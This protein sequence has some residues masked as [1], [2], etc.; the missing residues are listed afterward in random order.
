MRCY[1]EKIWIF[2]LVLIFL[3][4]SCTME[5]S[6]KKYI[7]S[8]S[9]DTHNDRRIQLAEY[10]LTGDYKITEEEMVASLKSF[11]DNKNGNDR[12]GS[13][14]M[15]GDSGSADYTIVK[16]NSR[17]VEFSNKEEDTANPLVCKS[18]G[19]GS[20]D[21]VELS[22]FSVEGNEECGFALM[23]DDR[24]LGEVLFYQETSDLE[25]DITGDSFMQL[26]AMCLQDYINT[27]A[28]IW[29]S[30]DE[31]DYEAVKAKY[32][33]TDEDIEKARLA[34]ESNLETKRMFGTD[35]GKWSSPQRNVLDMKTEW[36]QFDELNDAIDAVYGYSNYPVGCVATAAGQIMAYHKYPLKSILS[37]SD[38]KLLKEKYQA[39]RNW[40]GEYNWDDI[41]MGVNSGYTAG[42]MN[43]ACLMYELGKGGGMKYGSGGSSAYSSN[44]M[45]YLEKM[46][47]IS[48]GECQYSFDKVKNSI[49]N[50]RPVMI[51]GS[52]QMIYL[53]IL[54]WYWEWACANGHAWVIDGYFTQERNAT[55]YIFWIPFRYKEK[56]DYVHCNVGWGGPNNGWYKSEVFDMSGDTAPYNEPLVSKLIVGW[57]GTGNDL[58]FSTAIKIIPN[59]RI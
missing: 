59:I 45:K 14:V 43:A 11:L 8:T 53:G 41:I 40:N 47:Y 12:Q 36:G 16:K 57:Q 7:D 25:E 9:S 38:M 37:E 58:N 24:R 49:D 17:S 52:S 31:S 6:G 54:F 44:M 3:L 46:G 26:Y 23:S 4:T 35:Y 19:E 34:E 21:Y 51:S 18:S 56:N 28:D 39:A 50:N 42:D 30:I 48:D 27:T 29:E 22:I 13:F 1:E 33:I 15:K 10:A 32:G 20:D 5:S 2:I 55:K